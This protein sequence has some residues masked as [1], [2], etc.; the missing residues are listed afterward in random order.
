MRFAFLI[1]ATNLNNV[2]TVDIVN[3]LEALLEGVSVGFLTSIPLGPIGVL[4][5]QRT[6]NNGRLSGFCSGAGAAF[7]DF[8]YAFIAVYSVSMV[9]TFVEEFRSVLFIIGA[10]V[11]VIIGIRMVKAKPRRPS[12]RRNTRRKFNLWQNFVSTFFLTVTNP[13]PLFIFIGGFSLIGVQDTRIGRIVTVLGVLIGALT[14]WLTLSFLVG[15][16]R[17]NF[18]F[19]KLYYTNKIAGWVIIVLAIVLAIRE[20]YYFLTDYPIV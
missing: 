2:P 20:M 15:I 11:L 10:I 8:L 14:W 19:R 9:T 16:F 12:P 6:L 3:F 5:V 18:T 7:S 4:C 13:L 1:F 17:K